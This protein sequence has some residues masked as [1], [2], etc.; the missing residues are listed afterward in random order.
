[1]IAFVNAHNRPGVGRHSSVE[2][3]HGRVVGQVVSVLDA[4]GVVDP[5]Q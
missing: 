4:R 1:M 5:Q 2:G 3:A